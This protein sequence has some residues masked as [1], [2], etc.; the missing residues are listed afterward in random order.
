MQQVMNARQQRFKLLALIVIFAAPVIVAW[1][2]VHWRIGIPEQRTAHGELAPAVPQLAEWP[3]TEPYDS[4]DGGDW[5]LAFDCTG[6]SCAA[7]ADRW[8]RLHRALGRE[9]PRVTRLRIGG[10]EDLLPGEVGSQWQALPVWQSPGQVW[11]LDP[12]GKAVLTYDREVEVRHV[13]DDVSHLLR[14]NPDR[15]ATPELDDSHR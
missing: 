15:R 10:E 3:L 14:M 8:W 1:V 7:E 9:A 11:V 2:M 6:A 13:M 4:L 12:E 5:V